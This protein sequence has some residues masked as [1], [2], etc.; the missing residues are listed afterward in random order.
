MGGGTALFNLILEEEKKKK[1]RQN[2]KINSYKIMAVPVP[3]SYTHLDV[4]KRQVLYTP[5]GWI[6]VITI[7]STL[8]SAAIKYVLAS[9]DDKNTV[10]IR[11][12]N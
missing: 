11:S 9:S 1:V 12:K 2:T 10:L 6:P 4:Y 7:L 3:V 5:Q 8:D